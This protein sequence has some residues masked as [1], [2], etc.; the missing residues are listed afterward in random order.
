MYYKK[1]VGKNLYLSPMD[2]E[3]ETNILTKWFNEDQDIAYFNGFYGSLLGVDKTKELLEK[4]NE[5]PYSFS[6]VSCKDHSFMGH[7]SLFNLD[8][9]GLFATMG[10]YIGSEYRH[11][12]YGQEAMRLLIDYAFNTLR[13][14]AIHLEVFSYNPNAYQSYEKLGFVE[15]GRW[16]QARF[17]QGSYH[18]VI[19]MELLR[20]YWVKE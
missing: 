18:D 1:L 8:S 4:F 7:V 6:I 5:G 10:I 9:H 20:D 14:T 2:L 15:C 3:N 16:H 13:L 12:G 17:H 19:L 11:Q